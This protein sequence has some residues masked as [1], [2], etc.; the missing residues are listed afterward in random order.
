MVSKTPITV[1][2]HPI[3]EI[4]ATK[5]TKKSSLEFPKYAGDADPV[6]WTGNVEHYFRFHAIA[7]EDRATMAVFHR[8][9]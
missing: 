9:G 2:P 1:D 5:F 3:S 6:N 8:K 4:T 7:I